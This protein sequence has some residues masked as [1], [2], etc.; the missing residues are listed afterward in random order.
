MMWRNAFAPLCLIS[1]QE[2]AIHVFAVELMKMLL[3]GRLRSCRRPD[4]ETPVQSI[5]VIRFVA[6][7]GA[8]LWT[9][10]GR[11]IEDSNLAVLNYN[12]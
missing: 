6:V 5:V 11:Y 12:A 3:A 2:V 9:T 10:P 8:D 1:R 4:T 7:G